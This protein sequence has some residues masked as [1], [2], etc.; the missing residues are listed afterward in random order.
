MRSA[1]RSA[2]LI[3]GC[4]ALG[5]VATL[6]VISRADEVAAKPQAGTDVSFSKVQV[7][8]F[9]KEVQ[10]ILKARCLKCHGAEEKIK[11]GL[12]L[13][14]RSAVLKGG[15]Q[16]SA[17]DLEMP[18]ESLLIQAINYDRLEMPPNGQLPES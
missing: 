16:G 6:S 9:E 17:V 11:G 12:R 5:A 13:V 18:G 14:S 8:F 7:E 10:P 15:D 3:L 1:G 2:R 4:A